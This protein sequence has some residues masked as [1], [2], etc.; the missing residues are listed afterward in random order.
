[1]K[2]NRIWS[3]KRPFKG[4]NLPFKRLLGGRFKVASP[5]AQLPG[6]WQG[7]I[8][9]FEVRSAKK[10]SQRFEVLALGIY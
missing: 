4:K 7:S 9:G 6:V 5:Y 8:R 2:F 10:A 1:L 3:E